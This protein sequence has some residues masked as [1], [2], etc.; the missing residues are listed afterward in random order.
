MVVVGGGGGVAVDDALNVAEVVDATGD[1]DGALVLEPV[2]L[3]GL[4]EE[5]HEERVLQVVHRHHEPLPFLTLL[6]HS[7]PHP[8]LPRRSQRRRITLPLLVPVAQVRHAEVKVHQTVLV[9][10][11]SLF[12]YIFTKREGKKKRKK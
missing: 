2:L 10:M 7:Y 5:P 9:V 11:M 8:P 3:L 1:G 12:V 6:P 4:V